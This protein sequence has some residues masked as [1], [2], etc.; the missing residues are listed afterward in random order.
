MDQ[1]STGIFDP[2]QTS[3]LQIRVSVNWAAQR[4]A[5]RGGLL[6]GTIPSADRTGI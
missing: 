4:I 5:R 1:D 3:Q 6:T 2:D